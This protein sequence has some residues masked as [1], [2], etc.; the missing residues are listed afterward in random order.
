MNNK[1]IAPLLCITVLTFAPACNKKKP[2]Q[3]DIKTMIELDNTVFEI[4]EIDSDQKS[5]IKF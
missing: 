1:Y 4:E 2:K 3:E 5:N